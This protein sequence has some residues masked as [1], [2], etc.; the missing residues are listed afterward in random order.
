MARERPRGGGK[1]RAPA[2]NEIA[3]GPALAPNGNGP[4]KAYRHKGEKR[5]NIPPAAIAAEGRVPAVPKLHYSYSLRLDPVLRF[6][7]TGAPDKLPDLARKGEKRA[8][9]RSRSAASGGG[10]ATARA[11]A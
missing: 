1:A 8:F 3:T 2:E 10:A 11:V 6:D 4:A 7:S 9:S 5:R